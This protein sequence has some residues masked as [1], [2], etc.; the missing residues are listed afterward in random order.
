MKKVVTGGGFD[1]GSWTL[2][3]SFVYREIRR[4]NRN[5]LMAM[6]V[7]LLVLAV[8][9]IYP[10]AVKKHVS[11][12]ESRP[13]SSAEVTS[14]R[15]EDV[16]SLL[17]FS[18]TFENS[19][20][21]RADV[22]RK[23]LAYSQSGQF[24]FSLSPDEILPTNVVPVKNELPT[25]DGGGNSGESYV[26]Y[27]LLR[28]GD[29]YLFTKKPVD[30]EAKEGMLV[31]LPD[32]LRAFVSDAMEI[33]EDAFIPALF[34]TGRE[35]FS[36]LT[37]DFL[38][39]GILF[40]IWLGFFIPLVRRIIDPTRHEAYQKIYIYAGSTPDNIR[41]LDREIAGPGCFGGRRRL[42]TPSWTIRRKVFSF[43]AKMKDRN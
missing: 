18:A 36:T 14:L 5:W 34:D 9:L 20:D 11:A 3:N 29:R 40:M 35:P 1:E 16:S 41:E 38:F 21:Y 6:A 39:W 31:Y 12:Q 13:L 7:I 43:E 8:V 30:G 28:F 23:R 27:V 24:I 19:A 32:D 22:R 15:A 37:M 33:P 2:H 25:L 10:Y 4:T 42:S 17:P 26:E